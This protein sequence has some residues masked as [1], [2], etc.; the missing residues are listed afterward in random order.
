MDD[1]SYLLRISLTEI[2]P[3][4]W[5]R[6]VVPGSITLDRL[7]DVIQIVMGWLDYHAY[8]FQIAGNTY[9][10]DSDYDDTA[11][12]PGRYRLIDLIKGKGRTFQYNY[13]FGDFWQHEITIENSHYSPVIEDS[14][15][16]HFG[17]PPI[18]CL[19]GARAC[20]PEDVGSVTGY[21]AFCE[22][23]TDP[24][25]KEHRSMKSW[26]S[27][28]SPMGK[29]HDIE[30]FDLHAVNAKLTK[31]IRWSQRHLLKR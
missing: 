19:E 13:D 8:E 31:Y 7:H 1:R 3:E 4:I 5:R 30:K 26:V 6:F 25:H 12:P 16:K 24:N 17:K 20:P 2:S 10:E 22:A 23:I 29:K 28:L 9:T 15:S 14:Y 11:R 21:Y 18:E 27:S